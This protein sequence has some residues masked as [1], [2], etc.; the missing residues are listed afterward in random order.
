VVESKHSPPFSSNL[1][2]RVS[3]G[4]SSPY[5]E[6]GEEEVEP[7]DTHQLLFKE[8]RDKK[9]VKKLLKD[10]DKDLE[11]IREKQQDLVTVTGDPRLIKEP[12][13]FPL[14]ASQIPTEDPGG[15]ASL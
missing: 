11:R 13:K 15:E 1:S 9:K 10:M 5:S 8:S 6:T 14:R 3:T 2:S 4:C 12:I 7:T